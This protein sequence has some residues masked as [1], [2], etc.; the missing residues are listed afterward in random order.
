MS[1]PRVTT[2][3]APAPVIGLFG[4]GTP[5]LSQHFS[6]MNTS[7]LFHESSSF[8]DRE[9]EAFRIRIA[10]VFGCE[11]CVGLRP[12]DFG[13]IGRKSGA[14][15]YPEEFYE[16]ILDPTWEGFSDRER[17]LLQTITRF[18]LD[19]EELRDDDAFWVDFREHFSEV[20]LVDLCIH[21]IGPTLGQALMVKTVLGYSEICEVRPARDA[22]ASAA[23][24]S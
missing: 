18:A 13:E 7:H 15:D 8:S 6:P 21:M 9:L 4:M 24:D 11:Y 19:H 3:D 5:A 20:E 17:L 10:Y 12:R 22:L 2:P 23:V 1:D 14:D 16:H